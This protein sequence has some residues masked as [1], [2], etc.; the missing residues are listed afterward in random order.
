MPWHGANLKQRQPSSSRKQS[1]PHSETVEAAL[2]RLSKAYTTAMECVGALHRLD[3]AA[4]S[5][6]LN[7]T[8]NNNNNAALVGRVARAARRT[9]ESSILSDPLVST[10][11]HAPSWTR[12]HN[13]YNHNNNAHGHVLPTTAVEAATPTVQ[14]TSAGHQATVQKLA[15][16]SLVNYGDLLLAGIPPP[17]KT[18]TNTTIL[19][20]GVVRT[21][22]SLSV[23]EASSCWTTTIGEGKKS[24]PDTVRLALT[25]YMD[26][27]AIDGSDPTV[28][29]KLAS[30]ARRLGRSLL[31]ANDDADDGSYKPSSVLR[32][33]HRRLERH[34]LERAV[35]ALP[36]HE[37]PNRTAMRAL[38]EWHR[39][40]EA[41]TEYPPVVESEDE[42][43]TVVIVLELTRYSWSTLGRMMLRAGREG[44]A[45]STTDSIVPAGKNN[46]NTLTVSPLVRIRLSPLLVLPTTVLATV[47]S[48]LD[49]MQIWRFEATCRAM[50]AS[51][52]SA[53]AV[54]DE[55]VDHGAAALRRRSKHSGRSSSNRSV[56]DHERIHQVQNQ[57]V[58]E[59]YAKPKLT[60][61][62]QAAHSS[63]STQNEGS[64]EEG[65]S[66]R[67]HNNNNNLKRV[68]K[69]VR[70]Q[71]I[72][73]GKR[74]VRSN[75]RN[76]TE[77]CLLAATLGC[78]AEDAKY[79]I[80]LQA[81]YEYGTARSN[82]D[83]LNEVADSG[84]LLGKSAVPKLSKGER[85]ASNKEDAL[86]RLRN[87]SLF[88]F[89]EKY[90]AQSAVS[91]LACLFRFVAH[92]SLHVSR[93]FSCD[94][95]GSLV[96][97]SCLLD[98]KYKDNK[99]FEKC[100]FENSR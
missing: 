17:T 51:I 12:A 6:T 78:T 76:S 90:S 94:P 15:Y 54:L 30:A 7:N 28:W 60:E 4:M 18:A 68:S 20:R 25:A 22:K 27:T 14:L 40:N 38:D 82:V 81:N 24:E 8:H 61:A 77:Y 44:S 75:R 33:K 73:S 69:R 63:L 83:T 32:L 88:S 96:M 85:Y 16:L 67:Q 36:A 84:V 52:I 71:I 42:Q 92:A 11:Q 99:T 70:S 46:T 1:H 80:F 49:P 5:A 9:L 91:P 55:Y 95:G 39:E 2:N 3:S 62:T 86:E 50:S 26:A 57:S 13:D 21:L 35:T 66:E 59:E 87:W 37:P 29:L 93:V 41:E 56:D 72:T 23:S 43:T 74:A 45:Y 100:L 97:S 89:V 58:G 10:P 47:V 53:R 65:T 79:K 48:Y 34:A 31:H 19:D 64:V 98:C